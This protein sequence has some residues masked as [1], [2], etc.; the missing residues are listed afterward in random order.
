MKR[1][2]LVVEK[3]KASNGVPPRWLV[4]LFTRINVMVYG[5]SRGRWM[6]TLAGR[7]ICLVEMIGRRSQKTITIPLMYVPDSE[8]VYLVASQGG[9]PRHPAWYYNLIDNPNVVILAAGTRRAMRAEVIEGSAR[10]KVWRRCVECYPEY[11]VYRTRTDRE[12]PV[13]VCRPLMS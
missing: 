4:K 8:R 13:F 7:P 10:S 11:E 1:I 9:A 5:G 12:I 6:N 2:R 3:T